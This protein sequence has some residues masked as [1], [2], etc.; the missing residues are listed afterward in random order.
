MNW[1]SITQSVLLA[2]AEVL[3]NIELAYLKNCKMHQKS[4]NVNA[5]VKSGFEQHG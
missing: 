5:D 4:S 3:V 1:M 2:F